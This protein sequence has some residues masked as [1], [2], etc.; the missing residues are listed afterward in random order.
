MSTATTEGKRG[1]GAGRSDEPMTDQPLAGLPAEELWRPSAPGAVR[2]KWDSDP[3]DAWRAWVKLLKGRVS[4]GDI[5]GVSG[6]GA[7]ADA[8]AWGLDPASGEAEA[9]RGATL[10]ASPRAEP[11]AVTS[12]A[13]AFVESDSP[14]G[15]GAALE[16][17]AW[18]HAAAAAA[19]HLESEL[20]W[21]VVDQLYARIAT[22]RRLPL[23]EDADAETIL[24]H[25]LLAGETALA[26]GSLLPEV[27]P[28]RALRKPA[29]DAL[30]ECV[31]AFTD[32]EGMPPARCLPLLS[33]LMACW[34]RCRAVAEHSGKRCFD[35]AAQTQ[36]EWLVRQAIR[37]AR[38]DGSPATTSC[39]P[40]ARG[41]WAAAI[42]LGGDDSDQTAASL[43][44]RP[45]PAKESDESAPAASVESEWSAVAVMAGGWKP[46]APRITVAYE[47]SR[48]LLEVA[49]E[50]EALVSGEWPID[51]EMEGRRVAAAGEWE[52]QCWFSD[53]DSDYLELAIELDNG[54]KLER[55]VF[56]AHD[57]QVAFLAEIVLSQVEEPGAIEIVS[58]LPLGEG[59]LSPGEGVSLRPEEET[60]E[61]WLMRGDRRLAGVVPVACPEWK[62]DPRPGELVVAEGELRQTHA[63]IARNLCCPLVIDFK[64]GRFAKQRTWRQLAVA[65]HLERV[66]A[67]VAVGYR[68]QSGKDQL[69]VYRSLAE[70]AN[71]TVLGQNYSSEAAIARFL[72]TGEVDEYFEIDADED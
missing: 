19:E 60:R 70:P 34:T 22:A 46:K 4:V 26:L 56:L 57:M 7:L 51:L 52:Q 39:P 71:R 68:Y 61:G 47:G 45:K 32:G 15:I 69:L 72:P 9:V 66:A 49:A 63:A 43:R 50:G 1:A 3:A 37:L 44:L 48:L 16:S 64:T 28:L 40:V 62:I 14:L 29:A 36:Y 55:Q 12:A 11:A 41:L 35:S 18:A 25:Q 59:R 38:P 23:E 5:S 27:Q 8:V 24:L 33:L 54:A 13:E 2:K 58:R 65:E 31:L 53:L 21:R 67:D 6:P 30:S 10:A 17:V 20:W 42:G